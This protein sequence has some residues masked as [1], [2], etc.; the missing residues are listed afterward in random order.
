LGKKMAIW[1][2]KAVPKATFGLFSGLYAIARL[3]YTAPS[4]F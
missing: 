1:G 3:P 2:R 4:L